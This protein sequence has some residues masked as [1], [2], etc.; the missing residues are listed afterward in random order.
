MR[1]TRYTSQVIRWHAI[2]AQGVPCLLKKMCHWFPLDGK[3]KSD[4]KFRGDR[5]ICWLSPFTDMIANQVS[6]V[7][8]FCYDAA[9]L[10][11]SVQQM[12]DV[13]QRTK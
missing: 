8:M 3:V 4:I 6:E 10:M 13:R 12:Y 11:K 5:K 9:E 7:K 2:F 1:D